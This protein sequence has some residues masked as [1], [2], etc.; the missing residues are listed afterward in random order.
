MNLISYLGFSKDNKG[1][2]NNRWRKFRPTIAS[3]LHNEL[4]VHKLFLLYHPKY[5]EFLESSLADIKKVRP[6]LVIE[7]FPFDADDDFDPASV[8]KTL[9]DFVSTLPQEEEYLINSATG[10]SVLLVGWYDLLRMN[11]INAKILQVYGSGSKENNSEEFSIN[12]GHYRVLDLNLSKYDEYRAML[13]K[14]SLQNE[15]SLKGGIETKSPTYNKLI[16]TIERVAVRNN[17]PILI[18]GETGVGKSELAKRLYALKKSKGIIEGDFCYENCATLNRDSALSKL[19]GHVKGAYTGATQNR[20]G[21]LKKAHNGVLFLDEIGTLPLDVQGMLL[22]AIES[23]VFSPM[24]SEQVV[25]SNFSLICGTNED[26]SQAVKDGT[27]RKDLLARIKLWHFSLPALRHRPE[28]IEP[29]I[30][31]ELVKFR[32]EHGSRVK[33]S[34]DALSK[35]LEFAKTA[36]WECNFRDLSDSIKRMGTLC[37]QNTISCSDVGEEISRLKESWGIMDDRKADLLSESYKL[38]GQSEPSYNLID[39]IV[40]NGVIEE[41]LK[42][43]TA[44]DA[45]IALYGDCGQNPT[46]RINGVLNRELGLSFKELKELFQNQ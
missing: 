35:F 34:K 16:E 14:L 23:G 20:D 18:T 9:C 7:T 29:N 45:A 13:D 39:R 42:H 12:K 17:Y 37:Y 26:L 6:D 15:A 43:K 8:F 19:F 41:S 27:F 44:K 11:A 30:Q 21:L 31:Y 32:K 46:S 10:S 22:H 38:R 33:F 40:L 2:K 3:L 1:D 4:N 25:K 36:R 5:P 28:D 24:G